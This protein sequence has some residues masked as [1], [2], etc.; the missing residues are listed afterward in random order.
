MWC[1]VSEVMHHKLRRKFAFLTLALKLKSSDQEAPQ[2]SSRASTG[3]RL[4]CLGLFNTAAV[5]FNLTV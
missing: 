2:H 3:V 1:C 4:E 5:F